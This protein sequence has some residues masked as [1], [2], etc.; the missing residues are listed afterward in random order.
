[1]DAC[2]FHHQRGHALLAFFGKVKYSFFGQL[3]LLF[4]EAVT[5]LKRVRACGRRRL[6]HW[7]KF[8]IVSNQGLHDQARDLIWGQIS[9]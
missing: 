3:R 8:M 9:H 4:G 2:F 5:A 6:K 1:V 7:T